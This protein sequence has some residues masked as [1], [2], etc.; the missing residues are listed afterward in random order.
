MKTTIF[1]I[2]FIF[3]SNVN[4]QLIALGNQ[5]VYDTI[6][7]L[8][9]VANPVQTI[10]DATNPEIPGLLF[11]PTLQPDGRNNFGDATIILNLN[12]TLIDP[13]G[14]GYKG[15]NTWRRPL[16]FGLT[17]SDNLGVNVNSELANL[18]RDN[19]TTELNT[20]FTNIDNKRFWAGTQQF[21]DPFFGIFSNI[22]ALQFDTATNTQILVNRLFINNYG[23]VWAVT[24]GKVSVV[25]LPPSIYLFFIGLLGLLLIGRRTVS[26]I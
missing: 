1:L 5:L 14:N 13:T 2:L 19:T 26:S 15:V 7:D 18:F 21:A 17:Q 11:S 9:W 4:A 10:F 23:Y 12:G 25:P 8:T 3:T 6:Q 16:S 20:A 24:D 22:G